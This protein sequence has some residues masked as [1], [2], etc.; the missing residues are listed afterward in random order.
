MNVLFVSNYRDGTG[1]GHAALEYIM[2]MD[3]AG[4][5]VACRPIRLGQHQAPIPDRV[6]ELEVADH[7]PYDA[8]V[9]NVLPHMLDYHGGYPQNIALY[10][11]ETSSLGRTRWAD[12]INL[13][14]AAWVPC[15]QGETASLSSGVEIPLAVVPIPC[16]ARKYGRSYEPLLVRKELVDQ[17]I[18]YSVGEFNRRKNLW[19]LL[20]AFHLEFEVNEP[21]SLLIKVAPKGAEDEWQTQ[22]GVAFYCDSIKQG[23]KLFDD[24]GHYKKEIILAGRYSDQEMMR[25]HASCDCGVFPSHG[26][27]WCIPAFDAMAM[28]KTPIVTGWGGFLEYMSN[29]VGWLVPASMEPAY[30]TQLDT[31]PDL[32]TSMEDWADIDIAGLR[33]AMRDAYER[34]DVRR[35]KALGGIDRAYDFTYDKVGKTILETLECQTQ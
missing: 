28:G 30:G 10:H 7:R 27:A 22:Q 35:F 33:G 2:A 6:A 14:D 4:I 31:F 3:A 23:L 25:L 15:R 24:P 32:H 20:T 29:E 21:V 34:D 12:R 18:F 1:W 13:M 19:A 17:F 5:N 9:Q 11:T 8:V 16:D 26:E